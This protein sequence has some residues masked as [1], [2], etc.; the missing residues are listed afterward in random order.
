MFRFLQ[1]A[2]VYSR[3][4][5]E[6][7]FTEQD[8]RFSCEISLPFKYFSLKGCYSFV[9]IFSIRLNHFCLMGNF[10]TSNDKP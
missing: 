3:W 2:F 10:E 7:T 9:Y 4:R 6:S 5:D 8:F 1:N